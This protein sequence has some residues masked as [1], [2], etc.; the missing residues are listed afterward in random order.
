[1]CFCEI[2]SSK[3]NDR[4]NPILKNPNS[5]DFLGMEAILEI[6]FKKYYQTKKK[7]LQR[8]NQLYDN[9]KFKT[10]KKTKTI[11]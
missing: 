5:L 2:I 1:M 9:N 11:D 4:V 8:P 6:R 10:E 7:K 3:I